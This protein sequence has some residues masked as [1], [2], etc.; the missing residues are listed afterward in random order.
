MNFNLSN[1]SSR[2]ALEFGGSMDPFFESDFLKNKD[3][4]FSEFETFLN[5]QS[6]SSEPKFSGEVRKC[7]L[8]L[9]HL[10]EEMGLAVREYETSHHPVL[11]ATYDKAGSDKPTLLIYN[12]YDVQPVDPI[13]E[14]KSP[15]FTP[16]VRDG[17]IYARG[18]QDNKGQL[19]YTLQALRALFKKEGSLPVNLKWC[20]EGE[21]ECGS[22]GLLEVIQKHPQDFKADYLAV[23]DVGIPAADIPAVT[24]G[25]R[26]ILTFDV[27]VKGSTTDLHSGQHG[28]MVYNPLHALVEVLSS[29]KTEKG[30]IA[31]PG[32]YDDVRALSEKEKT[33]FSWDFDALRYEKETGAKATGGEKGY[34]PLER[35]WVRPTIEINGISGGYAGEGFKTVI[36][37]K[38]IAKISCRLVPSQDPAKVKDLITAF[39]KSQ[40]KEGFEVEVISHAG[41]GEAVRADPTS[42]V[43]KAFSEAFSDVFQKKA[44][45]ILDGG[46]IP[47]VSKLAQISGSQVVLVGLGLTTDQIHAPNEHFGVE[48]FRQGYLIM[49]RALQLLS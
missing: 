7:C 29:L 40:A 47:V 32:F 37:A 11:L 17:Q 44:L 26:G 39:I 35:A 13:E 28:G 31:I 19:F 5:F 3:K 12:H 43:V 9:K 21:E 23:V 48:R 24:L 33:L 36:P 38:A 42:R 6:I 46:S 34:T 18:A 2:N 45:F 16:T 4:I 15:P 27:K 10:L 41:G 1:L 20:I 14:W 30:E 25:V 22:Q 49:S 8:W